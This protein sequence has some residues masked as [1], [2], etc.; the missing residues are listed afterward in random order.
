MCNSATGTDPPDATSS[1]RQSLDVNF[2]GQSVILEHVIEKPAKARALA[3]NDCCY[4]QPGID[5]AQTLHLD[6]DRQ[7]V[8]DRSLEHDHLLIESSGTAVL[9]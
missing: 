9:R 8:G 2:G 4:R 3:A 5:P 1:G 7:I 6:V